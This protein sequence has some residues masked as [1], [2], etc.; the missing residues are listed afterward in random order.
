[1]MQQC[2]A[3]GPESSATE[4]LAVSAKNLVKNSTG[5]RSWEPEMIHRQSDIA[6]KKQEIW[7][8]QLKAHKR[9]GK[10]II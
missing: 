8:S 4:T 6:K 10:D 9:E 2:H 1:M 5:P 3:L 7:R